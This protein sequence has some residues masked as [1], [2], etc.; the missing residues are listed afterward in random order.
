MTWYCLDIIYFAE[1]ENWKHCS[2]IIFKCVNSIMRLVFNEKF[3]KKWY[4]W[5]VNSIRMHCSWLK[6]QPLRLKKKKKKKG[7]NAH[8]NTRECSKHGSKPQVWDPKR[9]PKQNKKKKKLKNVKIFEREKCALHY[10]DC[11]YFLSFFQHLPDPFRF[12]PSLTS[13]K[14]CRP[15]SSLGL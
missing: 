1:T 11:T 13:L 10:T 6:G 2:K 15:V 9:L 4:L 8:C 7:W 12:P 14:R 5:S 3:I